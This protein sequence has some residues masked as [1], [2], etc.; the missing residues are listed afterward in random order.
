MDAALKR[1]IH[2]R[3][4]HWWQC[5]GDC[6]GSN[7]KEWRC[8]K[9]LR[10]DAQDHAEF[11]DKKAWFIRD[12]MSSEVAAFIQENALSLNASL[13]AKYAASPIVADTHWETLIADSKRD[14][15]NAV[16]RN[17]YA[18]TEILVKILDEHSSVAIRTHVYGSLRDE[19]ILR[20][21]FARTKGTELRRVIA[22]NPFSG[23]WRETPNENELIYLDKRLGDCDPVKAKIAR[24]K[25]EWFE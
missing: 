14:V 11:L 18:P 3:T 7:P 25:M 10:W 6:Q 16:A 1:R 2:F 23:L 22:S 24:E 17:P 8:R 13:R 21:L 12:M 15:L 20:E 9:L 5:E 4:D 19:G